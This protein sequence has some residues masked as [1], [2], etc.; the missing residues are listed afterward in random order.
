M[1]C[2]DNKLDENTIGKG[3]CRIC[4]KNVGKH[5]VYLETETGDNVQTFA[6]IYLYLF[7]IEPQY[8]SQRLCWNCSKALVSAYQLRKKIEEHEKAFRKYHEK[9][10]SNLKTSAKWSPIKQEP[11]IGEDPITEPI[12][13]KFEPIVPLEMEVS[14]DEISEYE[15]KEG[16]DEDEEEEEEEEDEDEEAEEE[17]ESDEEEVPV[18]AK[19]KYKPTKKKKGK[20]HKPIEGEVIQCVLCDYKST[21][22]D[23]FQKHILR[24]HNRQ[25]MICDGC[26]E[27]FHLIYH[28]EGH[29]RD[30]HKFTHKYVVNLKPLPEGSSDKKSQTEDEMI[31]CPLCDYKSNVK[32]NYQKH[33]LR[34]HNRQEMKCDGCDEKY[35]LIYL[36]EDHRR[37]DHDFTHPYVVDESLKL[38]TFERRVRISLNGKDDSMDNEFAENQFTCPLCP[39]SSA[40]HSR[41]ADH[42]RKMHDNLEMTCDGCSAKFHLFYRLLA[43]RKLDHK[44]EHEY[45]VPES[46][47]FEDQHKK[48]QRRLEKGQNFPCPQCDRWFTEKRNVAK[49]LRVV[50]KYI[51]Y[52][53][54]KMEIKIEEGADPKTAKKKYIYPT[55]KVICNF[56]GKLFPNSSLEN[57]I[58][59]MHPEQRD[60]YI[61]AYCSE[62]SKTKSV[63][64]V[65]MYRAH[66]FDVKIPKQQQ[67]AASASKES[68]LNG[69][70]K[71]PQGTVEYVCRYC[72]ESFPFKISRKRHEIHIHTLE[73]PFTCDL[74]DKKFIVKF[75][76]KRHLERHMEGKRLSC[77]RCQTC[78]QHFTKRKL[79]ERHVCSQAY[80]SDSIP[81]HLQHF[82]AFR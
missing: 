6:E 62:P 25:E 71:T 54:P 5:G 9:T 49:H 28:L 40:R 30:V 39:Y 76:F 47:K 16:E 7:G 24:I 21:V 29:R 69:A 35:H 55:Y 2:W 45:K 34:I 10:G 81:D 1:E 46:I 41:F 44:F 48:E 57:H 12:E 50:H 80:P 33:V 26:D 19:Y 67:K 77:S 56:C 75:E 70:I 31:Y 66:H 59:N 68:R 13:V 37:E 65:H 42:Y 17:E 43:H 3:D 18:R 8:G 78:G 14:D 20:R 38:K 73:Y 53:I 32:G 72:P 58:R 51:K 79:L 74:C 11:D 82:A 60:P 27:T 4:E 63:L 52:K 61:C 36:L 64:L 15:V 23:N 22:R